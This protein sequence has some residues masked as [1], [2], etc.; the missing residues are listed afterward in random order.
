[1]V[2]VSSV[3]RPAT[4]EV[5]VA[6]DLAMRVVSEGMRDFRCCDK[7]RSAGVVLFP[8]A[9]ADRRGS[10]GTASARRA[11]GV[12][13]SRKWSGL[14]AVD[15]RIREIY[16]QQV[17]G[18]ATVNGGLRPSTDLR[19]IHRYTRLWQLPALRRSVAIGSHRHESEV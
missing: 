9:G 15:W 1:M 14:S 8:A 13:L 12:A 11:R 16:A 10:R 17:Q 4:V 18:L 7:R 19:A 2:R 3:K 6:V 5:A